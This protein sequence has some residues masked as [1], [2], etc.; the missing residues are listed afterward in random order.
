MRRKMCAPPLRRILLM[1]GAVAWKLTQLLL[2][3]VSN[4]ANNGRC[5]LAIACLREVLKREITWPKPIPGLSVR[6]IYD[7]TQLRYRPNRY[8]A[9]AL[10]WNAFSGVK[11]AMAKTSPIRRS[12]RMMRLVGGERRVTSRL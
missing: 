9:G 11:K 6:Q 4:C 3:K 8:Q 2:S 1:S 7:C 5:G 10:C 12:T